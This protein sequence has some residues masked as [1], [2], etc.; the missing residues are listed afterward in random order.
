MTPG[1]APVVV[2]AGRG[3]LVEDVAL[4]TDRFS[5]LSLVGDGDLSTAEIERRV[6]ATV[7]VDLTVVA[8]EVPLSFGLV[9]AARVVGFAGALKITKK[10]KINPNN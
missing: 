4:P 8:D 7:L 9:A 5:N 1:L 10:M 3:D 6:E 2:V